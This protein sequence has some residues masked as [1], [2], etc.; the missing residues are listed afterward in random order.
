MPFLHPLEAAEKVQLWFCSE[1]RSSSRMPPWGCQ[2]HS[3]VRGETGR[4]PIRPAEVLSE[5]RPGDPAGSAL[6]LGAV[7]L[8]VAALRQ[9]HGTLKAVQLQEG[10]NEHGDG[11][12]V[13]GPGQHREEGLV[14]TLRSASTSRVPYQDPAPS[15]LAPTLT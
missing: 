11:F 15:A 5:P 6:A 4:W 1:G 7:S 13:T 12:H 10:G 8:A 9:L 14:A 2:G 3:R